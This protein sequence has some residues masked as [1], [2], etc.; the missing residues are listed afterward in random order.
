MRTLPAWPSAPAIAL[1][2]APAP[3]DADVYFVKRTEVKPEAVFPCP[4]PNAT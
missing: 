2:F 1:L 3:W 4:L